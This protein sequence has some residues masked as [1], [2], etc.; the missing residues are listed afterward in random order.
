MDEKHIKILLVEDNPGDVYLIQELL[1]TSGLQFSI[2]RASSLAEAIKMT[3]SQDFDVVLLDLGL[4]DSFGLET[5]RKF[6]L[7]ENK[8]SRYCSHRAG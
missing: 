2:E 6:Q 4:P 3:G 5:L 1:R 7:Y 8:S